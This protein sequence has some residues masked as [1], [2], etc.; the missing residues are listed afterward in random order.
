MLDNK[1]REKI[2]NANRRNNSLMM[3]LLLALG[4]ML[5]PLLS[6]A[7][8]VDENINLI[9]LSP[10]SNDASGIEIKGIGIHKDNKYRVN[11]LIKNRENTAVT[12]GDDYIFS[13]NG[14][15]VKFAPIVYPNECKNGV[16]P[17]HGGCEIV[18]PLNVDENIETDI[19]TAD[20]ELIVPYE[21]R[22]G[23]PL[24]KKNE[25]SVK[26][27]MAMIRITSL[28]GGK[29]LN[30]ENISKSPLNI[31]IS[32][33]EKCISFDEESVTK[34]IELQTNKSRSIPFHQSVEASAKGED[35][36]EYIEITDID[37]KILGK[38][39]IEVLHEKSFMEKYGWYV[40]VGTAV[41]VVVIVEIAGQ[42]YFGVS[43]MG[44]AYGWLKGGVVPVVVAPTFYTE[45]KGILIEHG[46]NYRH[47]IVT[48]MTNPAAAA[49]LAPSFVKYGLT[50]VG[51]VLQHNGAAITW[52]AAK[53]LAGI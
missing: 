22:Y 27:V 14:K 37:G 53:Q 6:Y 12:L 16:L 38:G 15:E 42:M 45:I 1:L 30:I 18:M 43:P 34:N 51:G 11:I 5:C 21:D 47:A 40:G 46:F 32:P 7:E 4:M 24:A 36:I 8:R 41:A 49:A 3:A 23:Y 50:Y 19:A 28:P 39:S 48:I 2:M 20:Y 13:L 31:T 35:C 29:E 33:K 9:S 17:I 26:N 10:E 44:K 52:Q 25:G